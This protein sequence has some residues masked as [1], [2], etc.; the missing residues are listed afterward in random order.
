[1]E[2]WTQRWEREAR[3][4]KLVPVLVVGFT[5]RVRA[6]ALCTSHIQVAPRRKVTTPTGGAGVERAR[7][8]AATSP[9]SRAGVVHSSSSLERGLAYFSPRG[10]N[11]P[12]GTRIPHPCLREYYSRPSWY[13]YAE[14]GSPQI[15]VK[16]ARVLSDRMVKESIREST[17]DQ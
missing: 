6:Y 14:E 16:L 5:T 2:R 13:A 8:P 4:A 7:A 3:S 9:G 11:Y 10:G 12:P 17:F 1:M 15:L